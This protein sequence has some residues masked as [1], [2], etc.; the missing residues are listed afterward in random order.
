MTHFE[1]VGLTKTGGPLTKRIGLTE[2]GKL[3]SDATGCIMVAGEA[4][5]VTFDNLSQ[6]ANMI[7]SLGPAKA[8]ALG[9]LHPRLAPQVD[10]CTKRRL[11]ELNGEASPNMISRTAGYIAY[12]PR[13]PGLV[14]VDFDSKG[15]PDF[16][17][18]NID[19]AG[20]VVPALQHVLT[21]LGECGHVIRAST[22]SGIFRADTGQ[23][24]PGSNGVHIYIAAEDGSDA[25]RFLRTLHDRCWL[26]GYGWKM[27]GAAGQLLDRSIVDRMVYAAERLVFEGD[28]ILDEPLK[29]DTAARKP[30]V[31]E[32][33][34]LDTLTACPPLTIVE[35]AE[36]GRLQAIEAQR[37]SADVGAARR[38][39]IDERS[40]NLAART[41]MTAE[42]ARF[43][44]EKQ[45]G[46]VLMPDMVLPFDDP[47]LDGIT[48]RD[49]LA[50]PER[51]VGETLAD[52]IEGVAYG[53]GKAKIMSRPD[54]SLWINSF[55]HGRTVYELKLDAAAVRA[56]V[57]ATAPD[58]MT[59]AFVRHILDA[60][61]DADEVEQLREEV[62]SKTR[63]GK[64]RLDQMLK[65]ARQRRE[66]ER[67]EQERVRRQAERCDPRPQLPVPA[68]DSPW[69]PVMQSLNEVLGA[70]KAAE[71]PMR[72]ID[73]A[74]V[75]V[76]V[77]RVPGTHL[78]TAA[79]ANGEEDTNSR[80]PPPDQPLLSRLDEP[81]LA[82]L[83]ERHI[84]FITEDGRQVH[85]PPAFVKH[86]HS[87]DDNALPIAASIATL[88]IVLPGNTL[89]TGRGL[90]REYGIIFR[91]PSEL[92][93]VLP[94]SRRMFA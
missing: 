8:I 91:I 46:G 15:M 74:A 43:V 33:P 67:R 68:P 78:L 47:D 38:K 62:S 70:S 87:R 86:Y 37:L 66:R 75:R 20:G 23:K 93:S 92:L 17:R 12:R 81:Q 39:F 9:A 40:E 28:P 32:G 63:T 21:E 85:L 88:P 7:G 22:S 76:R 84:E 59:R 51:Y 73:G 48:V 60:E 45:C 83:V 94:N 31:W 56:A 50:D 79:G 44:I 18:Y 55:A 89:L 6:F 54:G 3:R 27:V 35:R 80:L 90:D 26:A 5:R 64:R 41:G 52:P 4:R 29:Q 30:I 58:D 19:R 2:D 34:P 57:A 71:P 24:I 13:R 77:R 82:E 61:L 1:I 11:A 14:L 16:V 65:E 10:V 49:V 25:E 69:L 42:R 53:T 72:D 36:L